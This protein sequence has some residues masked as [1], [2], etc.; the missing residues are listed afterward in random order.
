M[1]ILDN[2]LASV[3]AELLVALGTVLVINANLRAD[4][5]VAKANVLTISGVNADLK[6]KA[7]QQNRA[8]ADLQKLG[9]ARAR[10]ASSA[11][12]AAQKWADDYTAKAVELGKQKPAGDDCRAAADYL[13]AYLGERP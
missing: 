13:H 12:R 11:V 4:L 3:A 8:I 10:K 2:I 1:T 9:E 6:D 5:A 7:E